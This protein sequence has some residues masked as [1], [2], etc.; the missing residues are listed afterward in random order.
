MR[1]DYVSVAD[2]ETLQECQL[3]GRGTIVSL[4]AFLGKTRLIDNIILGV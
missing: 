4:A 3:A 2:P 1:L